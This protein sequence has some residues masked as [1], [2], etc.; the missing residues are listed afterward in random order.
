[1]LGAETGIGSIGRDE[2]GDLFENDM[3]EAGVNLLLFR[4]NKVT[5]TAIAFVSP[6]SQRT[7]PLISEQCRT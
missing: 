7:L 2:T 3:R 4:R 1:M 6:D 5:G